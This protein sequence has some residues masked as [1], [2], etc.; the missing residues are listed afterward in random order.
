MA[1]DILTA[2]ATLNRGASQMVIL[3]TDGDYKV[4][5][6]YNSIERTAGLCPFVLLP[7]VTL[8][9]NKEMQNTHC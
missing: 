7:L 1:R 9:Y 6:A 8:A 2:G 3:V 5:I 4:H